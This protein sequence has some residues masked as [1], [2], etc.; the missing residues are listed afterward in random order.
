MGKDE[1]SPE[2]LGLRSIPPTSIRRVLLD[3]DDLQVP[4]EEVVRNEVVEKARIDVATNSLH[5]EI[6]MDYVVDSLIPDL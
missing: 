3:N 4:D 2:S 6:D 1:T 5:E